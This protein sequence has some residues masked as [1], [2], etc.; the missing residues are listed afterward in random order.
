MN[1]PEI[2]QAKVSLRTMVA[3][4]MAA[5]TLGAVWQDVKSDIAG[6]NAA[7]EELRAESKRRGA[8]LDAICEAL[9]CRAKGLD[10]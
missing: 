9:Q 10:K 4:A 5:L 1:G 6:H 2:D 8:T 7:I 3:V